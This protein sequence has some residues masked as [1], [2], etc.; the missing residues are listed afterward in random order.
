MYS[1]A[2][3]STKGLDI[4]KNTENMTRLYGLSDFFSVMFEDTE[5]LNLMLEATAME[6]SEI[7]SRFLQLTSSISLESIQS[8][9]GS[10][11]QLFTLKDSDRVTGTVSTYNLPANIQ[12]SRYVANKPFLPTNLLE[13]LVDYQIVQE[14]D[15]SSTITLAKPLDQY[16]FSSRITPQGATEFALWFV[17]MNLDEQ[18]VSKFYGNLIGASPENSS[19]DFSNFVY[20]LYFV[21]THGPSV[22]MLRRGLNLVLGVPLARSTETILD[23]RTYLE[24]DQYIVITDQNQYLIPYGLAPTAE[25]GETIALGDELAQW[26][27]VKDYTKD[28]DWWVNLHIPEKIIPTLPDGQVNR[29]A[30][31]GSHLDYL[32]RAY[33]KK[34]TFLVKVKVDAFKNVQRFAQI[35]D[36]VE[37]AK[38]SYTQAIYVWTVASQ[39]EIIDVDDSVFTVQ[40]RIRTCDHVTESISRFRRGNSV[41][42]LTRG[43]SSFIRTNVP[44]NVPMLIGTDSILGNFNTTVYTENISGYR[45]PIGAIRSNTSDEAGWINAICTRKQPSWVVNRSQVAW[46]RSTLVGINDGVVDWTYRSKFGLPNDPGIRVIPLYATTFKDIQNKFDAVGLEA[47]NSFEWIFDFFGPRSTGQ[48]INDRAINVGTPDTDG[49]LASNFSTLF[50]RDSTYS[51]MEPIMPV[52]GYVTWAPSASYL[53]TGD[54]LLGV[55]ITEDTVGVYW[56]TSNGLVDAPAVFAVQEQDTLEIQTSRPICR[57]GAN[58][59]TPY[60]FTRGGGYT[61]ATGDQAIND[62]AID[63]ASLDDTSQTYQDSYNTSTVITRGGTTI[64]HRQ[65]TF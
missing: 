57:G 45:N 19:E 12:S 55:H 32:M 64:I 44:M 30:T 33:L 52:T 51:T 13:D 46:S 49:A 3:F 23:I 15:G 62:L 31:T 17:D 41:D 21:Y 6:A 27:E 8:A 25:I 22:S 14:A 29:Y 35:T 47:P 5:V 39:E 61:P 24:T 11:I 26:V 7:Y 48:A 20:G 65:R 36:I 50:F 10:Q 40:A 53:R 4:G 34:H 2:N 18:L 16:P 56:V 58:G 9:T 38:P 59:L 63:E 43:C 37:R 42:P 28:G 54:Y 60:Y 1:S